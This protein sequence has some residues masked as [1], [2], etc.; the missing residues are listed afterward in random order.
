LT[1][2]STSKVSVAFDNCSPETWTKD[3]FRLVPTASPT[4]WGVPFVHLDADVPPG[5][6]ATFSFRITAPQQAGVYPFS[7]G[8]LRD[9]GAILG[10]HSPLESIAVLAA[11]DCSSPGGPAHLLGE[12]LPPQTMAVGQTAP[13]SLTFANCS[14]DAWTS[15]GGYHLASVDGKSTWGMASVSLPSVVP[16]GFTVTI[17]LDVVAPGQAG[18]Y[19]Y[20][21]GIAQGGSIVANPDPPTT[22][23]VLPCQGNACVG[24]GQCP[25]GSPASRFIGETPPPSQ[26]QPGESAVVSETFVNCSGSTWA[27][28]TVKLG[29]QFPQDSQMWGTGRVPL[30]ADVPS[31]S[32]V[33]VAFVAQA[34][35][36]PGVYGFQW[37][38]V[39]PSNWILER[40]PGEW[41]TVGS[42]PPGPMFDWTHAR[43]MYSFLKPG[44]ANAQQIAQLQQLHDAGM[45]VYIT[46][47]VPFQQS[48]GVIRAN[49]TLSSY[50]YMLSL[51]GAPGCGTPQVSDC[52]AFSGWLD[53]L[54][55]FELE[56]ADIM[57]GYYTYDEPAETWNGCT[58]PGPFVSS[59]HDYIRSR[60]P[61]ATHRP[62]GIANTMLLW[63]QFSCG[64][65]Y[66]PQSGQDIVFIDQYNQA[67]LGVQTF[68][69]QVNAFQGW[70]QYGFPLNRVLFVLPSYLPS[71]TGCTSVDLVGFANNLNTAVR[72][73]YGGGWNGL[74]G[75]GYF[76]YDCSVLGASTAFGIDNCAAIFN[77]TTY[78]C[79]L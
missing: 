70:Q 5:E 45:N 67:N 51:V 11:A 64:T 2:G 47:P 78:Q 55:Q 65:S 9:A 31:G 58:V 79:S 35:A 56:N 49:P 16:P 25:Q 12:T 74:V 42:P 76:A 8:I 32:Q 48:I 50:H 38:M 40:S 18:S 62:I 4:P 71:S 72:S 29:S 60:D 17:S 26:M 37:E 10:E 69:N 36:T 68:A 59:V 57:A 77:S 30:P 46:D 52:P 63:Q 3:G 73:V 44:S 34:P 24:P 1:P 75:Y 27:A 41:I 61:D 13:A 23:Q 21:W 20:Q 33:T 66:L 43:L 19:A 6:R 53:Q 15:A 14:N 54:V 39:S 28:S 7:W 22:I